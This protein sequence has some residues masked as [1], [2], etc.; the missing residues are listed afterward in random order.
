ML[1]RIKAAVEGAGLAFRGAFH[2]GADDM[3]ASAPAGTLVMVGFVGRQQWAGFSGSPEFRDGR[4]HPL[5]RWSYRVVSAL[6]SRLGARPYFPFT[7]PFM[8]F[9]RWAQK[10]EAV[11]PSEIGM[12]IHPDFGLWHAWRGAL[13]FDDKFDLPPRD[14]RPRPCDSCEEKPCL[15][16]CPVKAFNGNGAYDIRACGAH[17]RRPEGVDC[18]EL[19][20]RAKRAC[21]VG[22]EF[23]YGREQAEF[24]MRA[25]RGG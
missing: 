20:C 6:A 9:V 1:S 4:P 16:T 22:A 14:S 17:I 18:V 2:P 21:P 13:A 11:A 3:P 5:D 15:S 23:R 25:F 19:G 24:H 7:S 10:A 8:P 12:L